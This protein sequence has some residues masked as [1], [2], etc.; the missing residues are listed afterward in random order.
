MKTFLAVKV[1][2]RSKKPGVEKIGERL[3]KVAVKAAPE[4]GAANREVIVRLADYLGLAPSRLKMVGGESS[5]NKR[6]EV[7]EGG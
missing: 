1:H 5:R 4:K 7:Q 6:I 2:P 3:F